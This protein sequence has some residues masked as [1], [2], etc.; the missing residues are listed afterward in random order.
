M[1]EAGKDAGTALQEHAMPVNGQPDTQDGVLLAA[2]PVADGL[3]PADPLQ[4][5]SIRD[6]DPMC[7]ESGICWST[8][9]PL[10][11]MRGDAMSPEYIPC[12]TEWQSGTA[13]A[14]SKE[15]QG[16]HEATIGPHWTPTTTNNE[17]MFG[18]GVQLAQSVATP[19]DN[20]G[21]ELP[22]PVDEIGSDGSDRAFTKLA[23]PVSTTTPPAPPRPR[24]RAAP[25]MAP[26]RRNKSVR[27]AANKSSIPVAKRDQHRLIQELQFVHPKENV[28]EKVVDDYVKSF[29]TPLPARAIQ[30][31][32][33]ATRLN[34]KKVAVAL[35]ELA[36]GDGSETTAAGA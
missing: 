3:L 26:A 19:E 16:V 1:N 29:K 24:T 21:H 20:L 34:N 6:I 14:A 4:G 22:S 17:I 13:A 8:P 32:R 5:I 10:D 9:L 30:A 7:H 33:K 36:L 11:L 35:E 27:L 25:A 2:D 23:A 28:T 15:G 12:S 31:L 18:A